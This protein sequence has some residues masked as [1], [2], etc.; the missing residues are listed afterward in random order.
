MAFVEP[1]AL[2]PFIQSQFNCRRRAWR[3]EEGRD[4]GLVMSFVDHGAEDGFPIFMMHGNP[5]WSFLWRKVIASLDPNRF[6]CIAPDAFGLG[7]S[8]K[9]LR[10]SDHVL[11][12]HIDALLH[13]IEALELKNYILVGQ[14]WGGPFIGGIAARHSERVK[15][16][17][18]GNTSLLLPKH[19]RTTAFHRLARS[20]IISDILF[21]L[22]GFPQRKLETAQ[23]DPNS[24]SGDIKKAYWWPLAKLRDRAAP[25]AMA[26]MVPDSQEHPSMDEL[27][28]IDT[29]VRSFSGPTALVWGTKDPILGRALNRHKEAL[30]NARIKETSAG[31]FLQEEVPEEIA[32]EIAWVA[33]QAG[34]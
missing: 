4:Q 17:V 23:G 24:I 9:W 7:T 34:I 21:R 1:A 27:R 13:L 15:G 5:T 25:L 30:P 14:D 12:R 2:P 10:L 28:K 29:W 18:L 6:R 20:P 3:M 22:L 26:R 19:F 31:H 33:D 32:E 8:S 11:E 16:L